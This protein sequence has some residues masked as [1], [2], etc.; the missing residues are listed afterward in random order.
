MSVEMNTQRIQTLEHAIFGNGEAGMK[1]TLAVVGEKV[2]AIGL[3]QTE[4][5]TD[6]KTVIA[7]QTDRGKWYNNPVLLLWLV[8]IAVIFLTFYVVLGGDLPGLVDAIPTPN[9][10]D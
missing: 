10:G 9:S 7:N 3:S 1:T 6:L 5:K 8:G 4:L 2:D